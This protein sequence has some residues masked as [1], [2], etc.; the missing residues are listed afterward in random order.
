VSFNLGPLGDAENRF[1]KDFVEFSKLWAS[2]REDWR[3]QQR[4][5]FQNEHLSTLG[6]SL[7]R[8][9]TALREFCDEVR[10]ADRVLADDDRPTDKLR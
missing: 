7:N 4:E 9:C 6:P 1:Q 3:D 5:Q 8:F 2:V 10:K